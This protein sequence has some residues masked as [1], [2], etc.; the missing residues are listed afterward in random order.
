MLIDSNILVYALIASSPKN[1]RAQTFIKAQ[2]QLVIAQQNIFET[3]RVITHPKFPTPFPVLAAQQAVELITIKAT[4]IH[5]TFET[6]QLALRLIQ[7]YH[8]FGSEIFDA[9]LV[10][11]ALSNG[12]SELATDNSKHLN[13]YAEISVLNP[14]Q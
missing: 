7:K 4:I 9:Y 5:P 8:I 10:A 11:T 14:F 6:T 3:L 1:E 13:K 12:I 2:K